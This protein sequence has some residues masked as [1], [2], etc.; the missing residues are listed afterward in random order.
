MYIQRD[1]NYKTCFFFMHK[2]VSAANQQDHPHLR[3]NSVYIEFQT[4]V[5]V[6]DLKHMHSDSQ[7]I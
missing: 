4:D 6:S 5:G 1:F 3:Y 7:R 2:R